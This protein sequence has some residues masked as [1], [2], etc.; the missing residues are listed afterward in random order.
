M[1][2]IAIKAEDVAVERY[3]EKV[4][5][6]VRTKYGKTYDVEMSM[7]SA[8]YVAAVINGMTEAQT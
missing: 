5:I 3:G 2:L 4:I 6:G 1:A 7:E 8:K